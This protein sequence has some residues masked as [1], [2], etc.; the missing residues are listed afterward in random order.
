MCLSNGSTEARESAECSPNGRAGALKRGAPECS[1]GPMG[2][3]E[4]PVPHETARKAR[5][6]LRAPLPAHWSRN[7]KQDTTEMRAETSDPSRSSYSG[8]NWRGGR[9][10]KT[11]RARTKNAILSIKNQGARNKLQASPHTE[12][13]DSIRIKI[14]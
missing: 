5:N 8:R 13:D 6:K 9:G 3:S 7:P 1:K 12:R 2:T 14:A 4:V 11:T 10:G